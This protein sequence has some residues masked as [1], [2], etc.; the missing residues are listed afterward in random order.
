M[1]G[2]P[3][4]LGPP[5]VVQQPYSM[6]PPNPWADHSNI[7]IPVDRPHQHLFH[8]S[9]PSSHPSHYRPPPHIKRRPAT[10]D[11]C[12]HK[13]ARTTPISKQTPLFHR[14]GQGQEPSLPSFHREPAPPQPQRQ[15]SNDTRSSSDS[16]RVSSISHGIRLMPMAFPPDDTTMIP[17]RS[18]LR[19]PRKTRL[20][21]STSSNETRYRVSIP[22]QIKANLTNPSLNDDTSGCLLCVVLAIVNPWTAYT[23]DDVVLPTSNT[24]RH[25][26]QFRIRRR[27]TRRKPP[28]QQTPHAK[29]APHQRPPN[30]KPRPQLP[31]ER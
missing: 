12:H 24:H 1:P 14:R 25:P 15:F 3:Q 18:S 26:V 28:V 5:Y 21:T 9:L 6:P 27:I 20:I 31:P 11:T 19:N 22:G 17:S 29:P 16:R 30:P 13:S 8:T 4:F 10:T 2:P 7:N 23:I